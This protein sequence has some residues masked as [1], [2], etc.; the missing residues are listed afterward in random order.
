ML[1]PTKKKKAVKTRMVR[2]SVRLLRCSRNSFGKERQDRMKEQAQ[3][4]A[5]D[6]NAE[7]EF[8]AISHAYSVLSDREKKARYDQFGEAG[9]KGA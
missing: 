1:A 7:K 4:Y 5:G 9:V 3:Q 6:K 8:K 2:A